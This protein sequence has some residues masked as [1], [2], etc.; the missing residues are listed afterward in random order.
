MCARNRKLPKGK[1]WVRT[2]LALQWLSEKT[3]YGVMAFG[4][5]SGALILLV[6]TAGI[7][8][9]VARERVGRMPDY[10][11]YPD[12]I[13]FKG[14]PA[15][16][17]DAMAKI[18][19]KKRSYS[20]FDPDLTRDVAE[21]YAASPWVEKVVRVDKYYPNGLQAEFVWRQPVAFVHFPEGN[22]AVDAQ[23]VILPVE[24]APW[25]RQRGH[26]PLV[27]G[28]ASQPPA[29]GKRWG[30]RHVAAAIAV[31]RAV[32]VEPKILKDIYIVDVR[33]LGGEKDP[34]AAEILLTTHGHVP[35][36]WGRSPTTTKYGEPSVK[37]KMAR[38][39]RCLLDPRHKVGRG[40][41]IDL[42]YLGDEGVVAGRYPSEER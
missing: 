31:L 14:V 24:Y 10:R 9:H 35:V 26:L 41:T 19:F 32:S 34:S 7:G 1:K 33:N 25:V 5:R 30:D 6:V 8:A 3:R 38:L 22:Y 17:A 12:R 4:L 15:W 29:H 13:K 2:R 28:V 16:C 42:R 18:T 11:V 40:S 21:A 20:I 39:R 27:Y 37:A 36:K 23:G